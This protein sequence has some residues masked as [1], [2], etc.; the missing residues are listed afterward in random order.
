MLRPREQIDGRDRPGGIAERAEQ[1]QVACKG[2]GIAGNIN[3]AGRRHVGYRADQ[4]GRTALSGGIEHYNVG[5]FAALRQLL[6]RLDSI[7]A[8]E[9]R[10]F[11]MVERRVFAGV[12]HRL[13]H[14]LNPNDPPCAICHRKAD[15]TGAAVQVEHR[16]P[17]G[18]PGVFAR[19]RIQ[20]LGLSM[21][22]L[23]KGQR[24]NL[25]PQAAH[26]ISQ[27][28]LPP[29]RAETPAQHDVGIF[30]VAVDQNARQAVH[31][32]AE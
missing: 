18:E 32:L 10:V 29:N 27:K 23:I 22:H 20:P 1:L 25:E 26:P 31:S 17:A 9:F 6:R 5:T 15:R 2:G 7:H 13:L 11:N 21:I 30:P 24:R 12:F 8:K 16:F 3:N 19:Q 4:L 28:I 14:R